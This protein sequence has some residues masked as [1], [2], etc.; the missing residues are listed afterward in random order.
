MINLKKTSEAI[1]WRV[2]LNNNLICSADCRRRASNSNSDEQMTNGW[3]EELSRVATPMWLQ[4][5]LCCHQKPPYYTT[6]WIDEVSLRSHSKG[7]YYSIYLMK[8]Y[9]H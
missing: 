6:P 4:M 1:N 7:I 8:R 9:G 5:H 2:E 3:I